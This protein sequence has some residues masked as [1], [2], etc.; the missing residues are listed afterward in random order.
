MDIRA[1]N[2]SELPSLF[3]SGKSWTVTFSQTERSSIRSSKDQALLFY[4]SS[5]RVFQDVLSSSWFGTFSASS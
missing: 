2:E 5:F 3:M 4:F 1:P